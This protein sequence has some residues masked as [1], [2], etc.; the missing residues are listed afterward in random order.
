MDDDTMLYN[1]MK[2]LPDFECWPI[3]QHWFKK[4]NIPPRN[5]ISVK[6]YI[7]SGYA[8]K[9]AVAPKDLPPI[10]IDKPQKDG[11]LVQMVEEPP[12]PVELVSRPFEL[13]EGEMFPAVL[14][15][16]KD[17]EPLLRSHHLVESE[18]DGEALGNACVS[19][20]VAETSVQKVQG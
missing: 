6:E 5:P 12:V 14:P 15:S 3:P 9:M 19:P 10:I 18:P 13:K 16:L 2:D 7:E 11:K 1:A 8:M 4:F 17:S 20:A